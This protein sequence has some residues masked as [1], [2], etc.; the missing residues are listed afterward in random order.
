[1]SLTTT[2][3]IFEPMALQDMAKVSLMNRQDTKY[4]FSEN[5]LE[6]VLIKLSKYYKILE[7]ESLR[8]MS[9][10]NIYFDTDK[11]TFYH[12]H[13]RGKLNRY[14]IRNRRY[15][16]SD[17]TFCEVKFKSNKGRTVK[18]RQKISHLMDEFDEASKLFLEKLSPV[19]IKD[20][21]AK[22]F[23]SFDRVTL[24]HKEWKDRCTIDINLKAWNKEKQYSFD[25]LAIA[26]LKQEKFTP[27]CDFNLV[28]KSESIYLDN[29]SKYAMSIS[30][31]YPEL[32]NNRFKPRWLMVKKILNTAK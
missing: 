23:M 20:L 16:A 27:Q 9:Y 17:L 4:I 29:F 7:I 30:K 19:P 25:G 8:L 3:D 26:E 5:Q 32:K 6:A 24:V 11:L 10:N 1:M 15:D 14:K 31:L 13:H 28:L 12:D 2:L 22:V 21:S 18:K